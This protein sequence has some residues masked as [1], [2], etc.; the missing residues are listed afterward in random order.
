M[1]DYD[2]KEPDYPKDQKPDWLGYDPSEALNAD[3][4]AAE[5][6]AR[7]KKRNEE[8][9]RRSMEVPRQWPPPETCVKK[10]KAHGLNCAIARGPVSLCGYVRVPENHPDADKFYDDVD[11]DAKELTFRCKA[12]E[13]GAWFG[14]DCAHRDD[15]VSVPGFEHPGNIWTVEDV[16]AETEKLAKQLAERGKGND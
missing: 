13:G 9:R 5:A 12:K 4:Q 15:W 7:L 1:S 2:P 10:W 6:L 3:K 14:F 16:A 11:V 8:N